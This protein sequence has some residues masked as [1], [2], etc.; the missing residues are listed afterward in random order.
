MSCQ[1][2]LMSCQSTTN[3]F[4]DEER[5]MDERAST[6]MKS[7]FQYS[8]MIY[9]MNSFLQKKILFALLQDMYIQYFE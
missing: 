6:F 5:F 9:N 2:K 4:S 7:C 3:D 8:Q 1:L